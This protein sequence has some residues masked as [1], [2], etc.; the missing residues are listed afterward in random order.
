MQL[1]I[2]GFAALLGFAALAGAAPAQ[3]DPQNEA[4]ERAR[5]AMEM[6]IAA[7]YAG[8][9]DVGEY[10]CSYDGP[11]IHYNG[12]TS[13]QLVNCLLAAPESADRLVITSAGGVVEWAI[14]A[15]HVIK[16]RNLEVEVIGL[17][18][19]SCANY[20]V[21]VARRFYADRY[22]A[23]LVHGAPTPPD[24]ARMAEAL[25]RSGASES[26]PNFE[27]SLQENLKREEQTYMIHNNF[28]REFN[29]GSG[30]YLLDDVRA[31]RRALGQ[32]S[33]SGM[34]RIDPATLKA[35]V[36]DLDAVIEEADIEALDALGPGYN[37]G[38]I[39]DLR[40]PGA[41]CTG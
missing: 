17:C 38:S 8:F 1:R 11:L 5:K 39:G 36:P 23:I 14:F 6:P 31:A 41:T 20:L 26:S 40:G 16:R 24:R 27:R 10:T 21:P 4:Y 15:A 19:S 22:A 30:Y 29:V 3:A 18:A 32:E 9:S 13:I 25:K 37:M 35:C 34:F 28:M 7:I 33:P 12:A 2:T